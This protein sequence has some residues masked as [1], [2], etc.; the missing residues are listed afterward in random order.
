MKDLILAPAFIAV[1]GPLQRG[2]AVTTD[3]VD[4]TGIACTWITCRG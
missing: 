3:A 1:N 2:R 4:P